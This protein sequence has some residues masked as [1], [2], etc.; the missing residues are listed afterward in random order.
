MTTETEAAIREASVQLD[1]F[2]EK[3][4]TF[5]S[6]IISFNIKTFTPPEKIII[7]FKQDDYVPV[8]VV[9]KVTIQQRSLYTDY[10]FDILKYFH[11]DIGKYLEGKFEGVGLKWNV[12]NESSIIKVEIIYHIDFSVIIKYSKKLTTQMNK[13]RR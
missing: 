4:S 12:L 13:C 5:L 6:N 8:S 3:I 2:I 1:H 11:N 7:V 10:G 9:N